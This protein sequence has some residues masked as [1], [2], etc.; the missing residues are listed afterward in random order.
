VHDATGPIVSVAAR[1]ATRAAVHLKV[2][3]Q[4]RL[5]CRLL[6]PVQVHD[7]RRWVE[8]G[9]T[10]QRT[11]LA[12]LLLA[13]GGGV[14]IHRLERLLW[15]DEPPE[16]SLAQIQ[17]YIYKL[18]KI[19]GFAD[20]LVRQGT[21]YALTLGPHDVLD[22][23][24]FERRISQGRRALADG[25][26]A[27]ASSV[28][29]EALT[30]WRGP[31][32]ADVTEDLQRIEQPRLEELRLAVLEDRVD[33]DLAAQRAGRLVPELTGLVAEHPLRERL[34]GQLMVALHRC[35]RQAEALQVYHA[36]RDVLREH[37]GL[38]PG[39]R[40]RRI[41]ERI[42]TDAPPRSASAGAA[43][44][45][46]GDD[47]R[48]VPGPAR[49]TGD[50][51][52][53]TRPAQLPPE[54]LTPVGRQKEITQAL[55]HLG[56]DPG[57]R[58]PGPVPVC[59][60]TGMAGTGK[61]MLAVHVARQLRDQ[62]PDGQLYADL[63]GT[64]PRP[65]SVAEVLRSFLQALGIEASSLPGRASER[66]ALYRSAVADRKILVL[67]DNATGAAAVR[68]LLPSGAFC[69]A[70]VTCRSRLSALA[71][72]GVVDLGALAPHQ[73]EEL[74]GRLVGPARIAAEPQAS[75]RIARACGG[76]PLALGIAGAR[77]AAR[78]HWPLSRL[79]A[80]LADERVLLDELS[81]EDT[82]VRDSLTR[83][84]GD[85]PGD[86]MAAWHALSH[87]DVPCFAPW[88][89]SVLLGMP[90]T[91][92]EDLIDRLV[93]ERLLEVAG[94]RGPV[95]HYRFHVL[96]RVVAREQAIQAVSAAE[97]RAMLGHAFGSWLALAREVE[98]RLARH[99]EVA[100]VTGRSRRLPAGVDLE[101]LLADPVSWF[102]HERPILS[103]VA[104]HARAE[105]RTVLASELTQVISR[106]DYAVGQLRRSRRPARPEHHRSLIP[107]YS[108]Y[109]HS[110][111]DRPGA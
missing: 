105:R 111:A 73:A 38:D 18:R 30:L 62:Y 45:G 21:G 93:D 47:P 79:A 36:G 86:M 5:M 103:A 22:L 109:A 89:A 10:K 11:V 1:G 37:S 67:L 59:V 96:L 46:G 8:T 66:I 3:P 58:A 50:T 57:A 72:A 23:I 85:L 48:S 52:P 81:L 33:A 83:G 68:P 87:L 13:R 35:G 12:A 61:S 9:G 31:A 74:L 7:G 69:A 29:Y 88:V 24:E 97:R 77:L 51:D 42:L 19:H 39:E 4:R 65:A 43:D 98:R 20:S 14:P 92:A 2:E 15:G 90:E 16:T 49:A 28:L 110:R 102:E 101:R 40:L 64:S 26:G 75:Q 70:V 60:V 53:P 44:H 27:E 94:T 82:A 17:T 107:L 71:G 41:H 55:D 95:P 32:L 54:G 84:R 63:R 34:R 106:L 99:G 100:P 104:T 76:L 108:A 78:P 56:R 6:G 25:R 91:T 80:R